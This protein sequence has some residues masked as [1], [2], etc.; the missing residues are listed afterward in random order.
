MPATR[1][2]TNTEKENA[3]H[4]VIEEIAR[5]VEEQARVAGIEVGDMMFLTRAE[6]QALMKQCDIEAMFLDDNK[7]DALLEN[8]RKLLSAYITIDLIAKH[9]M[10]EVL[11]PCNRYVG[12]VLL[13]LLERYSEGVTTH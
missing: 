1:L 10:G 4:P 8:N 12:V 2:S 5:R 3:M 13:A 9:G 6:A 7:V 11:I